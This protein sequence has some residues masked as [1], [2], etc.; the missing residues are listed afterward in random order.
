MRPFEMRNQY[1]DKL[2]NTPGLMWLGQ[3]T[4]HFEPHPCVKEAI[5]KAFDSGDYHVYAPPLG[6]EEIAAA[7]LAG[8]GFGQR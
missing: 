5:I 2:C 3:N 6:F 4:N 8:H 7:H 1:F